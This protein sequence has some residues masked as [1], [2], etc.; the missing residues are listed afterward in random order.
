MKLLRLPH[1]IGKKSDITLW[2]FSPG[3]NLSINFCDKRGKD[4]A[5]SI[6]V[7]NSGRIKQSDPISSNICI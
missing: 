2:V 7:S 4:F 6:I 3:T 5:K 1:S